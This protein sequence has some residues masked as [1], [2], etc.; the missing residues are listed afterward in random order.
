MN[1]NNTLAL[2][3]A[4]SGLLSACSLIPSQSEPETGAAL[5][6]TSAA[7]DLTIS[8]V[9]FE[10]GE[11]TLKPGANTIVA[12]AAAH[13]RA[14]PDSRAS[15]QGHTDHVG[16]KNF[17]QAL[18]EERASAVANAIKQHGISADRVSAVG[19]GES[20]PVANNETPDGRS[21]NRR[22]EI[23]FEADL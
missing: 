12:R 2:S 10:F 7:G 19:F 22:V 17:N 4:L 5:A 21:A 15:I 13:L 23:V 1:R 20:R 14:N 9:L 3:L 18:S 6:A 8:G 16:G 11:T